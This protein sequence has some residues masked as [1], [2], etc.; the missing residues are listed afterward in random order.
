MMTGGRFLI[1]EGAIYYITVAEYDAS[2]D[3]RCRYNE[4]FRTKTTEK[5][6]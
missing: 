2:R 6:C 4:C 3:L 5:G 1:S